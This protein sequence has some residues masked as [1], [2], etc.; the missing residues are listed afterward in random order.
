MPVSPLRRGKK[1]KKLGV[2]GKTKPGR[3]Y[4]AAM[5]VNYSLYIDHFKLRRIT[6]TRVAELGDYLCKYE[7]IFDKPSVY[8]LVAS[9][10][11]FEAGNCEVLCSSDHHNSLSTDFNLRVQD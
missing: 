6:C 2:G 4:T 7:Y 3:K 5:H 11:S 8:E 9:T 10:L 1:K